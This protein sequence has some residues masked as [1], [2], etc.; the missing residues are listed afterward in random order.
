MGIKGNA[1]ADTLAKKASRKYTDHTCK[2]PFTHLREK[3]NKNVQI[4][5]IQY[6]KRM[7]IKIGPNILQTII[8][9]KEVCGFLKISEKR[10]YNNY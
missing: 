5:R 3:L 4:I 2:I 9:T 6:Y 8:I 1:A 10:D 7:I